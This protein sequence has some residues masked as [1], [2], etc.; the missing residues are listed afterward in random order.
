[1]E[2]QLENL[3]ASCLEI[4]FGDVNISDGEMEFCSKLNKEIIFLCKSLPKSTQTD[5]LLFFMRYFQLPF[6]P[7]LKFFRNYYTPAWSIIYWLMHSVVQNK[8]LKQNDIQNAKIAHSMAL[9][10]HPLDDHLNDSELQV[11]YLNMLIRSQLWMIMN[12]AFESLSDGVEG[13][14]Q[15]VQCFI[16]DYYSSVRDTKAILSL[17][18]YCDRFRKQMAIWLIVPVLLTK[19]IARDE[20][21]TDTIQSA[22]GSFG[23]AW[24]LIDDI[25]DIKADMKKGTHSSVYFCLSEDIKNLWDKQSG[26]KIDKTNAGLKIICDYLLENSVIDGIKER[27]CDELES[28]AF[29][30]QGYNMKGLADEFRCLLS[31]L[32]NKSVHL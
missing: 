19:K 21:F 13:G 32:K 1:M 5:G 4:E 18:S 20:K 17:D 27:I 24:R 6:E 2:D 8:R 7:E 31:P 3:F 10:F 30:V 22:Y 11:T 15:L 16:D 9:F 25:K 29:I 12:K 23:I 26:E 14:E 28:A